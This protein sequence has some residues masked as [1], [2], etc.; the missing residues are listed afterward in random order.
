MGLEL[1][2]GL[3]EECHEAQN[4]AQRYDAASGSFRRQCQEY[5]EELQETQIRLSHQGA[6]QN[7]LQATGEDLDS[8][9]QQLLHRMR[10]ARLAVEHQKSALGAL[11]SELCGTV[12]L[13]AQLRV[14]AEA[15]ETTL[16]AS[17]K[18]LAEQERSERSGRVSEC[19]T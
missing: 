3:A 15:E 18:A 14:R 5:K 13:R 2:A 16:G 1:F 17:L 11:R 7:L 8:R 4:R 10:S 12:E 9:H 19:G 6:T